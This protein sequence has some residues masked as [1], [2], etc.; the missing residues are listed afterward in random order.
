MR[1]APQTPKFTRLAKRDVIWKT[2]CVNH[3]QPAHMAGE[4]RPPVAAH[5]QHIIALV[6]VQAVV[7]RPKQI[8]IYHLVRHGRFLFPILGLV[9]NISIQPVIIQ[10]NKKSRRLAGFFS[11][12]SCGF[13]RT[14]F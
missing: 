12:L 14:S 9:T 3:V 1:H 10:I 7:L 4:E 5:V 8:V 2:L 11:F 13:L 6:A